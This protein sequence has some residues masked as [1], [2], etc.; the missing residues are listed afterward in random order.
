MI[1]LPEVNDNYPQFWD[2]IQVYQFQSLFRRMSI[3]YDRKIMRAM[4][5]KMIRAAYIGIMA[6]AK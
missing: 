4:E 1:S 3:F 2:V 5:P 6:K